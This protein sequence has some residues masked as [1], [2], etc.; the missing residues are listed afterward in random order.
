M[1]G[2][3]TPPGPPRADELAAGA[4]QRGWQRLSAGQGSKGH[5]LDDWLLIDPDADEQH[6]LLVRRSISKPD[7]LTYDV[8]HSSTP[9]P[10][11]ELI[12]IARSRCSVKETSQFAKNE[13]G[14]NHYQIHRYDAWYRH[15]TLSMLAAAFL[16]VTAHTEQSHNQKGTPPPT[17]NT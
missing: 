11:A 5:R 6:L 14:L 17:S 2:L 16:A 9:L 15:I 7:Q 13:T 10:L 4:P 1:P 3:A 12:R 8:C